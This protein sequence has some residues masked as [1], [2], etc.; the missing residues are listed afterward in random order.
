MSACIHTGPTTPRVLPGRHEPDCT[1]TAC[2]GCEPCTEAHCAVCGWRHLDNT[3]PNVCPTCV[4]R[5]RN[6]LARIVDLYEQLP[7]EAAHH[8]RDS[9]AGATVMDVMG[10]EAMVA[11][12]PWSPPS[13]RSLDDD[14]WHPLLTL[15][16]W[17]DCWR[18]WLGVPT[19]LKAT[20]WREAD[21]LAEHL[22]RMAQE[23]HR[24]VTSGPESA[25][26][27][28]AARQWTPT[29]ADDCEALET[30][31]SAVEV[32]F[33]P[34]F[35]EFAADV[36]QLKARLEAVVKA[37]IRPVVGVRCLTPDCDGDL[38]QPYADAD[39]CDHRQSPADPP[40][41]CDQGGRRDTWRCGRCDRRYTDAEY[42][43]AVALW[44]ADHQPLRTA[45][46]I[47]EMVG[48]EAATLRQWVKR[49]HITAHG[50]EAR[51]RYDIREVRRRAQSGGL[52]GVG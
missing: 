29:P 1:D 10:G 47:R 8:S 27:A 21:F 28:T 3:H 45:A 34:D 4:G 20:V 37:S 42:R 6:D 22:T 36:R 33:A 24:A 26:D 31:R 23:T 41:G 15:A 17:V 49:G 2:T 44:Q 18:D 19:K 43:R 46:E 7:D 30:A 50:D 52:T 14:A 16:T 11:L 35:P 9:A 51:R 25:Q 48:I 38:M 39:P 32:E 12:G 13:L 5:T 40:C